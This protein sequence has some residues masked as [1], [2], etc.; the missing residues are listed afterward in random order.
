MT[1]DD[2]TAAN[3]QA[4]LHDAY[5]AEYDG[6]VRAYACYLAEVLFGLAYEFIRPGELVLDVGIGSGLSAAPFAAAGLIV[7]GMDFSPAMLELCRG[8]GFAADLRQHDLQQFPWPY[9]DEAVDHVLACGVFH[10]LPDLADIFYESARIVRAGGIVAF[11]TKS[12]ASPLVDGQPY[13]RPAHAAD[14]DI[15]EHD[16]AAVEEML[17]A[18]G[19]MPRK[20][21]RCYV[22]DDIFHVRVAQKER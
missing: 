18:S 14:L 10:F 4:A 20:A 7:Y 5:A 12:P 13:S 11:T 17:G 3:S 19:F 9:A 21:L 1:T 2:Q 16:P 22:G 6:Q 8:K 15:F